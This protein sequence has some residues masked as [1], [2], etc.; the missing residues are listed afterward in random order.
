MLM[1]SLQSLFTE[2]WIFAARKKNI[3]VYKIH[4]RLAKSEYHNRFFPFA[5]RYKFTFLY[6]VICLNLLN[7]F[8]IRLRTIGFNLHIV[9]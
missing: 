3:I 9:Y 1:Q 8:E 5:L 6:L 2:Y 4:I 7:L